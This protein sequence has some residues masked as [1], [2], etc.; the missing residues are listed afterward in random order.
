MAGLH[1]VPFVT[2][3]YSCA[4]CGALEKYDSVPFGWAYFR[5]YEPIHWEEHVQVSGLVCP[6]CVAVI[7]YDFDSAQVCPDD[8]VRKSKRVLHERRKGSGEH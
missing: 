6:A 8:D 7:V 4:R 1:R 3:D 5:M 2:N